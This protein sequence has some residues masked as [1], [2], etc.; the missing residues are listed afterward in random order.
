MHVAE[1]REEPN[2]SQEDKVCLHIWNS[3]LSG[4]DFNERNESKVNASSLMQSIDSETSSHMTPY[5]S[6]FSKLDYTEQ[7]SA[8]LDD[9]S[10]IKIE[11]CGE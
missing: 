10:T 1:T 8:G 3:S 11:D 5:Q 9:K 7:L 4:R 2:T 6:S